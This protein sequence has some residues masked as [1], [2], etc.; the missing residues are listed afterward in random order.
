MRVGS[1]CV[2]RRCVLLAAEYAHTLHHLQAPDARRSAEN[3]RAQPYARGPQGVGGS[4]GSAPK[5]LWRRLPT[6]AAL[7]AGERW[8]RP[9]VSASFAERGAVTRIESTY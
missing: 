5:A 4:L 7:A 2:M 6:P 1:S 9:D 3:S 8:G